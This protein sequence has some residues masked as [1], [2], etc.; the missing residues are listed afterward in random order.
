MK[1]KSNFKINS[2]ALLFTLTVL[3][4]LALVLSVILSGFMSPFKSVV[5]YTVVPLQSGVNGIGKWFHAQADKSQS[6]AKLT[7]DKKKLQAEVDKLSEENS[8][9]AQNKYELARLRELYKMDKKYSEYPKVAAEVIAKDSGNWF[10]IFTINRGYKDGIKKD[11]N[12]ITGGGLVG[13]VYD[14]GDNFAKVRSIIDDESSVSVEFA[15]T[16]DTGIVSGD[17]KRMSN[18]VMNITGIPGNAKVTGGEMIVTSQ[19][20]DKFLPGILVGY[21]NKIKKDSN[22][23]TK[24]GT[25]IP[26]VDFQHIS[27]VLVIKTTKE[28]IKK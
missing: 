1:K 4:V 16:K 19:I 2:K 12:V 6:V 14:V 20:S 11:M 10:D 18:G 26:S 15:N 22:E 23:L 7:K 13:I 27:E 28:Q 25:I 5:N 24:S 3:C 8:V 17:L 9:L 21:A